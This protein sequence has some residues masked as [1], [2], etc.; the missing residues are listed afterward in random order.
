MKQHQPCCRTLMEL[1]LILENPLDNEC[2][3]QSLFLSCL[4]LSQS[5][6]YLIYKAA[7][8][9]IPSQ[10][11]KYYCVTCEKNFTTKNVTAIILLHLERKQKE[12]YRIL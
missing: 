1:S 12:K 8:S 9:K 11:S 5:L 4:I 6:F 2:L 10:I 7:V 3:S